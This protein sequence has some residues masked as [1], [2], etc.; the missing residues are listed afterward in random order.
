MI[1]KLFL[2]ISTRKPLSLSIP[3]VDHFEAHSEAIAV[4]GSGICNFIAME[5]YLGILNR[6]Y[7]VSGFKNGIGGARVFGV[8]GNPG[9]MSPETAGDPQTYVNQAL[10]KQYENVSFD[11]PS[12]LTL[13]SANFF[14]PMKD[15]ASVSTDMTRKWG[16]GNV[17]YSGRIVIG[18]TNKT[19]R[20]LILLG[21][22]DVQNAANVLKDLI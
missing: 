21:L 1:R 20:E 15:V 10:L 7:L 18:L 5:Y 13:D 3:P 4:H 19:K 14:Y 22:Q 16:M 17:R 2:A 6:T 9:Y 8:M 12:F 11:S